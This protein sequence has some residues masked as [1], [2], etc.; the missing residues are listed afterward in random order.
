LF[1]CLRD[2]LGKHLIENREGFYENFGFRWFWLAGEGVSP[3]SPSYKVPE[4]K[5]NP[6]YPHDLFDHNVFVLLQEI[7]PKGNT[8]QS[9]HH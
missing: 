3:I 5:N 6:P 8:G 9:P 1:V 7:D 4:G 2:G